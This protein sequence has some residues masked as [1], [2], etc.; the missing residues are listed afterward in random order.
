[1]KRVFADTN[2]V[3]DLLDKREGFYKD[4]MDIFTK[5]YY[6][7]IEIYISPITYATASYLLRKHGK[8]ELRTLLSNLRKLTRISYCDESV[9]DDSIASDF[10]DFEDAMQ[11]FSALKSGA[12]I[13][14]TRN[15]KDFA[16]SSIKVI[17]PANFLSEF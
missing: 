13:I 12:E 1:M 4:A 16:K 9:V 7:E 11:Y 17:A 14:I 8:K 5:A 3:I 15:I 10:D 2:V 6:G